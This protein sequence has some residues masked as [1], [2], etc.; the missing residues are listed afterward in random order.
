MTRKIKSKIYVA[1]LMPTVGNAKF[2]WVQHA[3]H[4]PARPK[5]KCR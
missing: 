2:V 1:G 4:H 3:I 5:W